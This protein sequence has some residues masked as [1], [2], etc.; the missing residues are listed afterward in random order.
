MHVLNQ[1]RIVVYRFHEKGLEIF[2]VN[3][4]L[5]SDPDVWRIP[6][7]EAH[8]KLQAVVADARGSVIELDPQKDAQGNI[9]H[10]YAIEG[11][12]HDIPSIRGLIRYDLKLI[13]SKL[14]ESFP[15]LD[16]GGFF[17]I[18]E[19]LKRVMPNE[20]SA[21]KELKDILW[22]RNVLRNI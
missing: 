16:K 7:G 10:T 6:E 14:K 17:A 2:L 18:K 9:I 1:V 20:Y 12:W 15:E 8:P 19:A 21:L 13:K 5:D 11:D 22:D 4:D 3:H